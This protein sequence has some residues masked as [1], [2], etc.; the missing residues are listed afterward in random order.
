MFGAIGRY[1]RALGYLITGRIDAARKE[2]SR[3]P[4]T[5][6]ATYDRVIEEKTK[7]IQQYKEAVAGMIAQQEKKINKVKQL[8]EDL[9]KLETLKEGAAAKARSVVAEF[10]AKGV[11]ME[12][13]K[14]NEDYM[15]CLSA[16]NDFSHTIEEKS[17]HVVELEGDV[18]EIGSSI[19]NHKIQ[20]Q[21][22]LRDID[23]LKEEASAT[24]ADMITAKEEESIANIIAGI[25]EDRT[26]KELQEMRDLRAE[27]KARARI[28]REM[29]GTDTKQQEAEFLE[30]ARANASTDEFDKLIGLAG[31]ADSEAA[32]SDDDQEKLKTQ[33]PEQ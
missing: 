26:S 5:V 12:E 16:F 30:Y 22:L 29:A 17:A 20:L 3:N 18:N 6:R 23:K 32:A 27:G 14:R 24:V 19:K 7:R 33:L 28:S 31:E 25:S 13:I 21:E 9:N 4:Y 1:I 15:K 2:L 11:D 8:T 10:K